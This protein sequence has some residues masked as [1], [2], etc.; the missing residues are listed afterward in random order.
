MVKSNALFTELVCVDF[1]SLGRLPGRGRR[2]DS[3]LFCTR[4][5]LGLFS[6]VPA[7]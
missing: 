6:M 2:I 1:S 5:S 4:L 3:S 7:L